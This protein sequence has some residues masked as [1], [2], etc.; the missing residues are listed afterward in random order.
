MLVICFTRR[1]KFKLLLKHIFIEW[2]HNISSMPSQIPVTF[3]SFRNDLAELQQRV[4]EVK[5]SKTS[6]KP[7]VDSTPLSS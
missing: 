3:S 2:I 1:Y 4:P 6:Y 7:R 5:W